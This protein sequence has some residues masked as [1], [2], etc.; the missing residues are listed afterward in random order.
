MSAKSAS[1]VV[2]K[3]KVNAIDGG[4]VNILPTLGFAP[5]AELSRLQSPAIPLFC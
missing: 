5:H 1:Q 4:F 2:K 3:K